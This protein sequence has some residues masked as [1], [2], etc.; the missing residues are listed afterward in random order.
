MNLEQWF[1]SRRIA[2][3]D[4]P[5]GGRVPRRFTDPALEHRAV[6]ARAGLFDFSFMGAWDFTGPAACAAL[7]RMQ[8]RN[9]RV[10]PIGRIAYSLLLDDRGAVVIDAT[11]WRLAA[12]AYR[13][14]T[15]RPSDGSR[16]TRLCETLGTMPD[17]R[18]GTDAIIALQ[19]PASPT[20][21][22]RAIGRAAGEALP[23]FGFIETR[24]GEHPVLVGRLGYSGELGYE[25]LVERARGP[26]LWALLRAAGEDAGVAECGFEAADTL[27][28]ESGYVLFSNELVAG[29][30]PRELGLERLVDA[31]H[32]PFVG[33]EALRR[34]RSAAPTRRLAGL[35]FEPAGAPLYAVR[36]RVQ[37]T[38]ACIS[39]TYGTAIGLGFVDGTAAPGDIVY[40]DD[41]RRARVC[42]LPFHDA[43]RRRPRA[44]P[45]VRTAG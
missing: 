25:L 11:I 13:L 16:I 22:A 15:G 18:C 2:A 34:E 41:G 28:I 8:T 12:D 36:R 38:S 1:A 29:V 5:T 4:L 6:R 7:A 20:V 26:A 35:A 44:A 31:W 40:A 42:R 24:A 19:G 39:P 43:P 27:R 45:L 9:L 23:Y 33:R 10:L 21:L 37:P 17:D 14:F 32:G 3:L 30:T